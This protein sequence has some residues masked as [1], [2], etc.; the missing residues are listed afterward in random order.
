MFT[1]VVYWRRMGKKRE[2]QQKRPL[3]PE[4]QKKDRDVGWGEHLYAGVAA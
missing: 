1:W 2:G 3:G 4:P